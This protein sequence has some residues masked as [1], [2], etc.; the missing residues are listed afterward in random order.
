MKTRPGFAYL[1]SKAS[2][3]F[4][5]FSWSIISHDSDFKF[6]LVFKP[7][8]SFLDKDRIPQL[9]VA[10]LKCE[11]QSIVVETDGQACWHLV[12][13]VCFRERNVS[14]LM[15]KFV[16]SFWHLEGVG[17]T[18]ATEWNHF[19]DIWSAHTYLTAR[20]ELFQEPINHPL[21]SFERCIWM[22]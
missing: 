5:F 6:V 20:Y 14:C 17:D 16:L 21:D 12:C 19:V 22:F 8:F 4:L 10:K 3:M 13:S 7:L 2:Q 18:W 15:S 9:E 1:S 11:K